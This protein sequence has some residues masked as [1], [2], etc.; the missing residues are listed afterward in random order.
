[1]ACLSHPDASTE[2]CNPCGVTYCT[3]PGCGHTCQPNGSADEGETS[4]EFDQ[5]VEQA[6]RVP[7]RLVAISLGVRVG[8]E[9][10]VPELHLAFKVPCGCPHEGCEE[11]EGVIM[12]LPMEDLGRLQESLETMDK[13][14]NLLKVMSIMDRPT[15]R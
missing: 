15:G 4:E 2:R 7:A 1:M 14:E 10:R 5:W 12:H 8:D 6:S 13:P 11:S 9:E 3:G